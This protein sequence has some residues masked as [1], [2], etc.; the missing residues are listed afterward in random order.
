MAKSIAF[1]AAGYENTLAHVPEKWH[2]FSEKDMRQR[3]KREC[4]PI[5][6]NR[7]AL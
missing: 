4:I 7:D 2:R 6:S 1:C 5:Q 3:K